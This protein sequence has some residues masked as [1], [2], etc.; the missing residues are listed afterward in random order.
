MDLENLKNTWQ[1]EEISTPE[2]SLEQQNK[3]NNPLQKIRKNMQMEF[4]TNLLTF[5]LAL[6][7]FFW[8]EDLKIRTYAIILTLTAVLVSAFYYVKFYKLYQEIS[9]QNFNTKDSLISLKHQFEL[10]KQYYI[11]Y[12]VAFIPIVP[13]FYIL[14]FQNMELYKNK[15][16]FLFILVLVLTVVF[17]I[18]FLYAMGKW[19]F[20]YF[21]GK[22][23]KN[24][25]NILNEL[26]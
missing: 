6:I 26:N 8:I 25:E 19:W 11:S 1:K 14:I 22:H 15:P 10:N 4:W 21:Y 7:G 2:I 16:E 20:N 12:Y 13:S 3:I 18:Y 5:L 24:V 17:G 9:F 23:I